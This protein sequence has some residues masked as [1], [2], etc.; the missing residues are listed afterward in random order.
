[1]K[2]AVCY[3]SLTGNTAR[4]AQAV[5]DALPAEDCVYFGRP[6]SAAVRGAEIVFTGFWTD[7]GGCDGG[8]AALLPALAGKRVALFGTAGFGASKAY[9]DQILS[10]VAALL[11]E[12]AAYLGGFLC[13]GEMQPTVL[14]TYE[15]MQRDDPENKTAPMLIAAW[16]AAQGHPDAEDLKRAADFARQCGTV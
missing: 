12:D 3:S 13:A 11:P 10:R 8:A 9:F 14:Q 2:Y 15:K 7:K 1:M 5:R 6:D 4:L 16:H